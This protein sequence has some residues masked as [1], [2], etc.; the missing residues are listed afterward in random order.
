MQIISPNYILTPNELLTNQSVAFDKEIKKIASLNELK[1]EFP[2][3]KVTILDKN[4][5]LMPGLI[6]AHVHIEFS[7]NK[8]SLNYGNFVNWLFSIIENREYLVE[9]ANKKLI[10]RTLKNMIKS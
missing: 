1:K 5:L 9:K 8:T 7:A 4:S 10:N 3:A 2:H 6:N